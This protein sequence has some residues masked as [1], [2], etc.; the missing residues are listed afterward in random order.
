MGS[1]IDISAAVMEKVP[2]KDV[3]ISARF[4][5]CGYEPSSEVG[6]SSYVRL[7]PVMLPVR[8]QALV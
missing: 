1:L 8:L 3:M 4:W 2:F 7:N 5:Y 6:D